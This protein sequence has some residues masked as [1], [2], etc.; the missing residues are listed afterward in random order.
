MVG[1]DA[2]EEA[3][4]DV[5]ATIVGRESELAGSCN[6]TGVQERWACTQGFFRNLGDLDRLRCTK[7]CKGGPD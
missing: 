1:A 3:E 6:L 7:L 4:G 2:I 5:A